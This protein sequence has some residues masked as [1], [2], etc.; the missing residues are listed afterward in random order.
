MFVSEVCI[1]ALK[2]ELKFEK[3]LEETD[4]YLTENQRTLKADETELFLC[5]NLNI[6]DSEISFNGEVINSAHAY[7][8]LGAEIDSKLSFENHLNLIF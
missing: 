2:I 5:T 7:R 3:E 6:L 1:A 4:K 8:Y